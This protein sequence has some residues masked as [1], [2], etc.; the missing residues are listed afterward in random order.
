MELRLGE[1]GV[2]AT[3]AERP[4]Y[5]APLL[6]VHGLWTGI[7]IWR[8]F[9][10]HLAHRGWSSYQVVLRS[11]AEAP[12]A[13]LTVSLQ[14]VVDRLDSPPIVIGHGAGGLLAMRLGGLR[15]AV[16]LTPLLPENLHRDPVLASVRARLWRGL[17]RPFRPSRR[18][19]ARFLGV[20]A[21][22]LVAEPPPWIDSFRRGAPLSNGSLPSFPR[23]LMA[24]AEDRRSPPA[25]VAQLAARLSA[26]FHTCAG[27]DHALPFGATWERAVGEV[28]RWAIKRLG[29]PLLLLRGDEDLRE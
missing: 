24:G 5:D 1:F 20:R 21:E 28:H 8:N 25:A 2:T 23:L 9:A 10:T 29:E 19:A 22:V 18:Q 15:A 7:W 11:S 6:F 26:D 3:A 13:D 14:R 17:R 16:G 27:A 12:G 4:K